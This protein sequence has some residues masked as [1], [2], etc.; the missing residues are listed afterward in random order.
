M[1]TKIQP[2]PFESAIAR[3][4]AEHKVYLEQEKRTHLALYKDIGV[5]YGVWVEAQEETILGR[6][7]RER[8]SSRPKR[9]QKNPALFLVKYALFSH[10]LEFGANDKDSQ[11]KAS[12]YADLINRAWGER[13]SVAAFVPFA[14]KV[15]FQPK[16]KRPSSADKAGTKIS[17][18]ASGVPSAVGSVDGPIQLNL[19]EFPK[20]IVAQTTAILNKI[21]E[22]IGDSYFVEQK[23]LLKVCVDCGRA[24]VEAIKVEPDPVPPRKLAPQ[25]LVSRRPYRIGRLSGNR[26]AGEPSRPRR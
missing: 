24:V 12:S 9:E 7:F 13:V 14:Q 25:P 23:L 22:L 17:K 15:G 19:L 18:K 11:N 8:L 26:A 20:G 2:D 3:C 5:V 21:D 10:L 4:R 1:H 16:R 6:R